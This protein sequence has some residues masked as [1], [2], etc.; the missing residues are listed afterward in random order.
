MYETC[1]TIHVHTQNIE[2]MIGNYFGNLISKLSFGHDFFLEI[3]DLKIL[4]HPLTILKMGG[5]I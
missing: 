3:L 1:H 2:I 4:N 5:A